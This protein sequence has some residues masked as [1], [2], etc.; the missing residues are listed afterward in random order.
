M[1]PFRGKRFGEKFD[2]RRLARSA[3]RQIADADDSAADADDSAA[4][5][6]LFDEGVVI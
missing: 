2:D 1:P 3:G 5:F 4:Q 6:V